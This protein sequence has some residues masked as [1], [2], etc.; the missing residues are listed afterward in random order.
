MP[1][2]LKVVELSPPIRGA[3]SIDQGGTGRLGVVEDML[4]SADFDPT[5]VRYIVTPSHENTAGSCNVNPASSNAVS[6][7]GA[8][9]SDRTHRPT[10]RVTNWRR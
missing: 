5:G 3:A 1:Y 8:R 10:S 9:K 7:P 2:F 4:V 6:S